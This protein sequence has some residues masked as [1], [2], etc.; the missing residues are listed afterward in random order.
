MSISACSIRE[1][2]F[3]LIEMMIA[4]AFLSFGFLATSQLLYI[5]AA[6][7]SLARSK[8]T[9][10]VAAQNMI[11]SLGDSYRR[12]ALSPD[13]ALGDHGP[14]QTQVA[15][16]TDASILNRY[17]V[18]WTVESVPD[19]RPGK[20]LNARKVRV[21]VAPVRENG[22]DNNKAGLSKILNVATI[23]SPKV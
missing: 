14:L 1:H 2:G 6:S 12:N 10:G 11:E 20:I 19:P 7:T 5:A 13:L 4:L 15:N 17:N 3:T 8:S 16:P 9:A 23:F 22:A 18:R 21:T